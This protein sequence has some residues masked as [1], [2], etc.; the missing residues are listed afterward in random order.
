MERVTGHRAVMSMM[1]DWTGKAVRGEPIK[2]EP[3]H[4]SG[5]L[6]YVLDLAAGI[7]GL[8]DAP[9][10]NHS[11][12]NVSRGIMVTMGQIVE[13][14]RQA[15]PDVQFLDPLPESGGIGTGRGPADNTRLRQ[16]T[17]FEPRYDPVAG[18]RHY[19]EWRRQYGFTS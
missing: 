2:I 6:T 15:V 16:D 1:Y 9:R 19:I 3:R 14:F 4:S 7:I 18:I 12:Y 11:F 17:S 13:A 8:L 10:L 5:D